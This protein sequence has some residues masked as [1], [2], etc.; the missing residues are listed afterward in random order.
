[1]TN[2]LTICFDGGEVPRRLLQRLS[3]LDAFR[4]LLPRRL[5]LCLVRC[6]RPGVTRTLFPPVRSVLLNFGHV[7]VMQLALTCSATWRTA[8]NSAWPSALALRHRRCCANRL[9]GQRPQLLAWTPP[10]LLAGSV[11]DPGCSANSAEWCPQKTA[12]TPS[13]PAQS[14]CCMPCGEYVR[15]GA[16][17]RLALTCTL[18]ACCAPEPNT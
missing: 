14:R 5:A 12:S 9:R 18:H 3:S 8:S 13:C 10:G 4:L 16:S 11:F 17:R 2:P 15:A 6:A 7:F 1:M